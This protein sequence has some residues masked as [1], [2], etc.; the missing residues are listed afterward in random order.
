M[1]KVFEKNSKFAIQFGVP[2]DVRAEFGG[3][4][5]KQIVI[6]APNQI[7][8][9]LI[10]DRLS[11]EFKATV[12]N[13]RQNAVSGELL[14]P[15]RQQQIVGWIFGQLMG[16]HRS[17]RDLGFELSE[18]IHSIIVE[19]Y[20][21]CNPIVH[22]LDTDGFV[23]DEIV[24]SVGVFLEMSER[25][26]YHTPKK[27]GRPGETLLGAW[28]KWSK[29][30]RQRPKTIVGYGQNVRQFTTWFEQSYGECYGARITESHVNAF[31]DWLM[32]RKV[33]RNT[34]RRTLSG[35]K[36]IYKVGRYNKPTNPFARV[37]DRMV[38]E[39]DKL[40][41][42]A[43]TREEMRALLAVDCPDRNTIKLLAYSGMRLSEAVALKRKNFREDEGT[44]VFDL[45][46]AGLRKTKASYRL[47]PVH[48][49]LHDL[50]R[51]INDPEQPLVETTCAATLSKT[52]SRV[53]DQ[54]TTDP[55]ARAHSLRHAF[56]TAMSQNGT[57][58][59]LR[60]Q[61]VGHSGD[62]HDGYTHG[63]HVAELAREVAKVAY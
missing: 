45:T 52:L 17:D 21:D 28:D 24:K 43:F 46:Q 53:I 47:V 8:A 25:S 15:E 1:A 13:Y 37:S 10:G 3:L 61:I 35:L 59:P 14:S 39:G 41:V 50:F 27:V 44:W 55:S 34:I 23:Y 32:R 63:Q 36:L 60:M 6:D 20:D 40:E 56:I 29:I 2:E 62:V 54:V 22:G 19:A 30:A 9:Q 5:K 33:S 48:P 31:I 18:T 58:K 57:P 38:I 49:V 12:L 51:S 11:R 42:R 26:Q 7:E 16:S 4:K